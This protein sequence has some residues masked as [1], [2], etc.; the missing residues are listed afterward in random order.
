MIRKK[1]LL[2]PVI[3]LSACLALVS[4]GPKEKVPE[5][6]EPEGTVETF[7][8][9]KRENIGTPKII[10]GNVVGTD[11]CHFFKKNVAIKEIKV[12]IGDYVEEGDV[13][14]VA[15]IEEVKRQVASLQN[16]LTELKRQHELDHSMQELNSKR[17]ELELEA[18]E[19]EKNVG[20]LGLT[21]QSPDDLKTNIELENEG[22]VYNDKMYEFNVDKI[23]E[24]ITEL[25]KV[26]NDGT[27]RAK[28]SGYVTFVK[29]L[30]SGVVADINENIVIVTDMEDLF[31]SGNMVTKSYT[32]SKYPIKLAFINGEKVEITEYKYTEAEEAFYQA[33]GS[34]PIQRFKP[35]DE[36]VK[37]NPGDY[38]VME[39]YYEDKNDVLCIGKDAILSDEQGYFV[40]VK[41]EDGELEKRYCEIGNGDEQYREVISGLEEGELV[42]YTQEAILPKMEG[43]TEVYLGNW[44]TIN[45]GKGAKYVEKTTYSYSSEDKGEVDEI[46]V[47]PGQEIKKGDPL[48]RISIGSDKASLVQIEN[49]IS[50]EERRHENAVKDMNKREE[51]LN[52]EIA[53]LAESKRQNQSALNEVNSALGT[54]GLS[55]GDLNS[56][57]MS[58]DGL[59]KALNV[60]SYRTQFDEIDLQLLALE[61][62]S[63]EYAYTS[64]ISAL[65]SEYAYTK[66]QNNG[67]GYKTIYADFDGKVSV[68]RVEEREKINPG[69]KL[70]ETAS[71]FDD[72]AKFAINGG[73][74]EPT[75]F[76]YTLTIKD[77]KFKA[78]VVSGNPSG[79]PY[80]FTEDGKVYSTM[81]KTEGMTFY[82]NVEDAFFDHGYDFA[83]LETT[84]ESVRFENMPMVS[85]DYVFK[86]KSYD[87]E[88]YHYVWLKDGDNVFKQYVIPGSDL[89]IGDDARTIILSGLSVGDTVVK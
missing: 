41:H 88:I 75:G 57:A 23:N 58:K 35:V 52:K 48:M 64:T 11:Y 79:A 25:N 29:D 26:I 77:E 51:D 7:R 36:N 74:T 53:E 87:D 78:K 18:A 67:T 21:F 39:F 43:E 4:C 5:L 63:E 50:K 81:S 15:D 19:Y 38:I 44:S 27:L 30:K 13:L 22:N 34:F 85:G 76:E 32:Y 73:L 16:E 49:Q 28:S 55:D 66:E 84:M 20:S 24:S 45:T 3:L 62:Q 8:P 82:A 68:I 89:K 83:I 14:V 1:R 40:Y 70:L 10:V 54:S 71:Y 69:T 37:L 6:I 42:L 47:G 80:V 33:L 72:I 2:Q 60:C 46:Y 56:L 59:E 65:K 86:E 9:I 12:S 61:K 17:S 31:I